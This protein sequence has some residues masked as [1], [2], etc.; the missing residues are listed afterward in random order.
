MSTGCETFLPKISRLT[1][2]KSVISRGA[3]DPVKNSPRYEISARNVPAGLVTKV[4]G[5]DVWTKSETGTTEP[6]VPSAKTI[7]A[8]LLY[9]FA[10]IYRRNYFRESSAA[11]FSAVFESIPPDL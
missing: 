6:K 2:P 11:V 8:R 9:V 7:A 3:V 4:G 1:L 10:D 5:P